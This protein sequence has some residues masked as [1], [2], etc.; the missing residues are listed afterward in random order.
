MRRARS[1][2][3][4]NGFQKAER[5][6]WSLA[7]HHSLPSNLRLNSAFF[8]PVA[9]FYHKKRPVECHSESTNLKTEFPPEICKFPQLRTLVSIHAQP[10]IYCNGQWTNVS[11]TACE[12]RFAALIY[13]SVPWRAVL[14]LG[15]DSNCSS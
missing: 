12:T 8:N 10:N 15:R 4:Q 9:L 1:A 3:D 13:A 14:Q 7:N 5:Y 11:E 2:K 6:G